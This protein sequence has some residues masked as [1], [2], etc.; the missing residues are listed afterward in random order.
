MPQL[1]WDPQDFLE[2]LGV[3][4]EM[5]EFWD[6]HSYAVT[7]SGLILLV[8]VWQRESLVRCALSRQNQETPLVSLSLAVRGEARRR[9]EKWGEYL[10]L[11]GC[12][13]VSDRFGSHEMDAVFDREL[14]PYDLTVELAAHPDIRIAIG[15]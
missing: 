10:E 13:V 4:P 6:S 8:T 12:R 3:M 15:A 7:R 5:D 14:Y 9:R 1:H 2:C 11:L